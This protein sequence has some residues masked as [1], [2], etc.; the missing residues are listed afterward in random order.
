MPARD[1]VLEQRWRERIERLGQSGLTTSKFAEQEGVPVHQV[2]WW[3]RVL[4]RR[5]SVSKDEASPAAKKKAVKKNRSKPD[6]AKKASEF[7]PVSVTSS[8][9]ATTGIEIVLGRPH[10][11]A[12]SPGFDSDLLREVIRVLEDGSC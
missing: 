2:T 7:V 11:I 12:V 4:K 3:R 10:R 1:P 8:M 6:V 9:E 5:D